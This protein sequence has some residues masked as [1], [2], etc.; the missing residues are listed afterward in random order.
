MSKANRNSP[1]FRGGAVH[2]MIEKRNRKL[3]T[4]SGGC[5]YERCELIRIPDNYNSE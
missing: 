1:E 5:H 4:S 2:M 3:Y